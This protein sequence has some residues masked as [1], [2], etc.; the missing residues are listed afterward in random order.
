MRLVF[1]IE[2]NGLY[3]EADTIWCIC[4]KDVDTEETWDYGPD[5]LMNGAA[6]LLDADELIGHNIISYDLP[7][8]T[9]LLGVAYNNVITDTMIMSRLFNP[10][11][12]KPCK[13]WNSKRQGGPHSL[14]AWGYRVGR[15]KPHHEEWDRYSPEMLHRCQEDVEI[16]YLTYLKLL[17][18]MK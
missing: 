5:R 9:K 18:E 16:N 4:T 13:D 15:Y 11:R 12:R 2:A 17:E 3:D 8:L 10:D 1:D 14:A 7:L 6:Q